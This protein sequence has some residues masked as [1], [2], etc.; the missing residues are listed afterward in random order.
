MSRLPGQPTRTM[1]LVAASSA[2]PDRPRLRP[3]YESLLR[4]S[5]CARAACYA[6]MEDLSDKLAGLAEKLDASDGTVVVAVDPWED[7]SLVHHVA[8]T[9]AQGT[10]R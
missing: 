4:A 1:A 2:N 6:S 10:Q 9:L 8:Q 3:E 5:D 7:D